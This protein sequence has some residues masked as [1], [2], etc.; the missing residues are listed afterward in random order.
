MTDV[1]PLVVAHRG[2]SS[3]APQNTLAAFEAALRVGV[4]SIELDL[5]LSA[6]G[7]VVVIHDETVDATTS[8]SGAVRELDV[9]GVRALDAGAWFAPAF[10]GQRVPLFTEVVD[11]VAARGGAELLVELKG[12]WSAA[13]ARQVTEVLAAAGLTGRAVGQSFWPE[14]VAALR[15]ADPAL[16]RGLLVAAVDDGLLGLCAELGVTMCN[17]AGPVLHD[18]PTLVERLH[19]AGLEVAVWTLNEPAHWALAVALGVDQIITDRPDRLAGWL[20][21][22]AA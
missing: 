5:H 6:D 20:A 7:E 14:T 1:L 21:H 2:N 12:V 18:D 16:R 11:L 8:G 19:A 13:E 17:P 9:G 22:R 4:H 3:V 10:A 15:E